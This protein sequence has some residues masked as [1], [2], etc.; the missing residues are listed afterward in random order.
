MRLCVQKNRRASSTSRQ[1]TDISAIAPQREILARVRVVSQSREHRVFGLVASGRFHFHSLPDLHLIASTH[2]KGVQAGYY[3][4]RVQFTCAPRHV[5]DVSTLVE[6]VSRTRASPRA[7]RLKRNSLQPQS[8]ELL[9]QN[10]WQKF[11]T[12]SRVTPTDTRSRR[13]A[14]ETT[15]FGAR[16]KEASPDPR[17]PRKDYRAPSSPTEPHAARISSLISYSI[18]TPCHHSICLD[19]A[20]SWAVHPIEA[21]VFNPVPTNIGFARSPSMACHQGG[22]HNSPV[23]AQFLNSDL[24][25]WRRR[26]RGKSNGG[27]A[28]AEGGIRV[29]RLFVPDLCIGLCSRQLPYLPREISHYPQLHMLPTLVLAPSTSS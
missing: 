29:A 10:R 1:S 5:H 12:K 24:W 20:L 8:F 25:R 18:P 19:R 23:L 3:G 6:P 13:P 9:D 26:L 21:R 14:E 11:S 4:R 15:N 22:G 7:S 27:C 28:G 2:V 17:A 16:L